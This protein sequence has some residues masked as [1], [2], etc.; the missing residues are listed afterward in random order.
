M[1]SSTAQD[2]ASDSSLPAIDSLSALHYASQVTKNYHATFLLCYPPIATGTAL[3]SEGL[4]REKEVRN[5]ERHEEVWGVDRGVQLA[6]RPAHLSFSLGERSLASSPARHPSAHL[7]GS[8]AAVR[9]VACSPF[10]RP[11]H[12][13]R[14]FGSP[15]LEGS[16]WQP[17]SASGAQGK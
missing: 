6:K 14:A 10:V 8:A 17:G 3:V 11:A 13:G 15:G 5:R 2:S 12:R 1:R 4:R 16:G 9:D 7:R